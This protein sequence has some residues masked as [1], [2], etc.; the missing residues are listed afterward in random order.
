MIQNHEYLHHLLAGARCFH[1]W[2]VVEMFAVPFHVSFSSAP[3]HLVNQR[4]R[5]TGPMTSLSRLGGFGSC[6]AHYR[7]GPHQP[8]GAIWIQKP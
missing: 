5:M 8:V 6:R 3:Q 4:T 1:F 2:L 7:L